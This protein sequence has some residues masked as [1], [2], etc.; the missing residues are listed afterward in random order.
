MSPKLIGARCSRVLN[1]STPPS[2]ELSVY[3]AVHDRSRGV[4]RSDDLE[5]DREVANTLADLIIGGLLVTGI[6]DQE[7]GPQPGR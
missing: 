2:G 7:G 4:A 5:A 6:E 3:S 1:G